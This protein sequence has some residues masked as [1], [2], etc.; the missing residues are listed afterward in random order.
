MREVF[1]A[2]APFSWG[3]PENA[4]RETGNSL[5]VIAMCKHL[6]LSRFDMYLSRGWGSPSAPPRI[7]LKTGRGYSRN[8]A[9]AAS[10]R[11]EVLAYITASAL[12]E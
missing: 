4:D 10:I 2:D 8:K 6:G 11:R 3:L 12:A 7:Y 1:I 5:Q 9:R